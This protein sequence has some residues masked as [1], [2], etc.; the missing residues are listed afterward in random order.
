MAKTGDLINGKT[1][2]GFT[3]PSFGPSS[4]VINNNGT[5]VFYATCSEGE[6][7]GEGMF[8]PDSVLVTTGDVVDGQTLEGINIV[9][10]QNDAGRVV[11]RAL[12]PSQ[13]LAILTSNAVLI[14]TGERIGGE[15]LTDVGLP[16][17]N[18]HGEIAFVG[19]FESGTGIFTPTAR[20]AKS[21]ES[22]AGQTLLSFGPPAINDRGTVA[23]QAWLS[24][25]IATAILTQRGVLVKVGDT[26]SGKTLTDLLFGPA[27]NAYDIVA[28][29]GTFRGGTGV[30]TQDALLVQSG[31]KIGGQ[32]LTGFG[33][34]VINDR[35]TVAF[36]GTFPG[37]AGI[38]TQS[39]LVVRTGDKVNGRTV[40]GLG[41]PAIN[42]GGE[43]AFTAVFSDDSSAV[44]LAQPE[45]GAASPTGS[46]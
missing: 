19:A 41:Q 8:T 37:G 28:F 17:I 6:F 35:G 42:D 25:R 23:Y 32:E 10:A 21:G 22:I 24:G 11:L 36:F 40:I 34:P 1:L 45:M 18:N 46:F 13:A 7:A 20:L 43:L 2:T 31:D 3:L 29:A 16:A 33:L 14:R 39:S 30:F 4:P 26:I 15:I 27:L 12:L 5:V 38:F 9:P 44:V